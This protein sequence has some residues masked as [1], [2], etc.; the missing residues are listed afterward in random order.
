MMMKH[1][2]VLNESYVNIEAVLAHLK[3]A[4]VQIILPKILSICK[5][6]RF[7]VF[8]DVTDA[9]LKTLSKVGGVNYHFLNGFSR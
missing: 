3:G 5:I 7:E 2:T 1:S 6:N 4:A 8:G 9:L